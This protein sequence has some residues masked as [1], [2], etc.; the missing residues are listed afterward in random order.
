MP[1]R[2]RVCCAAL[3]AAVGL[4]GCHSPAPTHQ[5]SGPDPLWP[6]T[7]GSAGAGA[8][9]HEES[10]EAA[11]LYTAKCARC[12]KFY[13]PADYNDAEWQLWM[14]KM[15]RKA[16]LKPDQQQL[17][18]RYLETFRKPRSVPLFAPGTRKETQ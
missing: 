15:G 6:A 8:L 5:Q 16:R 2:L 18:S 12:H 4:A 10:R 13:N 7:P 14:S 3:I 17:L 11:R 9:S 1:S